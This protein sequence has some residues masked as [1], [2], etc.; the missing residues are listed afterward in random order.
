MTKRTLL[1]GLLAAAVAVSTGC[2]GPFRGALLCPFGPGCDPQ[3]CCDPC[4]PPCGPDCGPVCDA[5]CAPDCGPACPPD[6]CPPCGPYFGPLSWLFAHFRW[7]SFRGYAGCGEAYWGG[8][9]SDPPDCCDPC[10]CYGNWTGGPCV[11]GGYPGDGY[12]VGGHGPGGCQDC[13]RSGRTPTNPSRVVSRSGPTAVSGGTPTPAPRQARGPS[14]A[15][16]RR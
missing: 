7:H 12:M 10:D 4:G 1:L 5:P 13:A 16:V 8:Y 2:H 3:Y 11:G 6:C 9:C 14:R 15:P